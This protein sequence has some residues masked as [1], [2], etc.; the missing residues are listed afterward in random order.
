MRQI[1][2]SI[3]LTLLVLSSSRAA[4]AALA[5]DANVATN[6]TACSGYFFASGTFSTTQTNE[7]LLAFVQTSA[8]YP[9]PTLTVTGAGL[10]WVSV[11]SEAVQPGA[12]Q[13]FRAFSA[14]T[15]SNVSVTVSASPSFNDCGTVTVLSISGVDISGTNGSGAI[16]ATNVCNHGNG[17]GAT[18]TCSLTT[19]RGS[20]WVFGV[21]ED[22]AAS[23]ART[24][25]PSQTMIS[26]WPDG[27]SADTF[28]VQNQ[29]S[30][31]PVP[32]TSVTIND[33]APTTDQFNFAVLEVLPYLIKHRA[34]QN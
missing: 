13:V 31:T 22:Y 17:A 3:A 1:S 32:G 24:I 7:L 11:V 16:G 25:G 5:I 2:S 34:T 29:T 28:W 27:S 30:T 15:L 6:N 9:T 8:A 19:T 23:T 21:G 4:W 18:E 26:Q 10:T 20:S 14:S 12:V 33:T